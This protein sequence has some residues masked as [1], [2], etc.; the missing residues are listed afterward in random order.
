MPTDPLWLPGL[1]YDETELRKMDLALAMSDGTSLGARPGIRPGDPGLTV[2]I[3]SLTV[4]VSA[5]TAVLWRA[6]QGLYR[7]QLPASSPGTLTSAH[8]TF[9]RID[10]VYLRVW[11]TAVDASGLRRADTVLLTGAP[12]ATPAVPIPGATEVYIP[13]ATITVPPTTG[14]GAGSAT[15]SSTIRQITVA[16][17]GIL[18]VSSAADLALPGVHVGQARYNTVRN[19]PEYWNGT[20]WAAQGDFT[21]FTPAWT[22]QTT[23]PTLGNG[24]LVS[25]WTRVGRMI[26]WMGSLQLGSTS[27][28][29]TGLWS[30][31]VPVQAAANGILNV[32]TCDYVNA[33]DNEYVGLSQITNGSYV[34]GFLVKTTANAQS[35]GGV[36]NTVPVGASSNTRLHWSITYEAAS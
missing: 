31:S 33:G 16:P 10:L 11:D 20:S 9:S 34:L 26:T 29:G 21:S 30:M 13:L 18:P 3:A 36:S 12:S 35:S 5:G 2:T 27:N 17:G 19:V 1:S 28:G 7:A 23:N 32:G 14:G 4:N 6:G 25:R 22:A 24:T 8:A 15:V